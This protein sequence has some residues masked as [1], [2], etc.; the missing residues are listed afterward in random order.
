MGSTVEL[1][2][3]WKIYRS[4]RSEYAAL[5]GV[6][7]D[8]E[9]G[10]F[11]AVVGPSGSGKSTL[12]HIIGGLDR[13]TRGV[14]RV[15][16]LDL[17]K[18]SPRELARY[19]NEK[20]GFV[21]QMFNL[22]PYLGAL[23]NVA[24]PLIIR[25]V[26]PSEAKERALVALEAVGLRDKARKKPAEL[27]GGEQQRVAIARALAAG[28]SLL[29]ADEPTG[30]LDSASA[31]SVVGLF[32]ELSR[33]GVTVVMVTHNLELAAKCDRVARLKDGVVV[34]VIGGDAD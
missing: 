14:V 19:R 18:L 20:V 4:G 28:P 3:V 2:G 30:N 22:L 9:R 25:G 8:V 12:L 11:L 5:R 6:D 34:E 1:R 32:E 23:E 13:P 33:E 17:A 24:L 15:D 26:R 31:E 7:L 16:G 10:E 27:S 21:F 29:L